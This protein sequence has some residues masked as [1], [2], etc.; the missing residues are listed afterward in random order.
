MKNILIS[1][2]VLFAAC[3]PINNNKAKQLN[4][5]SLR[6]DSIEKFKVVIPPIKPYY[7]A[8][9]FSLPSGKIVRYAPDDDQVLEIWKTGTPFPTVF[10]HIQNDTGLIQVRK[11]TYFAWKNLY[12]GDNLK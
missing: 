12:V 5:D 9:E 11:V 1:A 7:S 3:T 6:K 8:A 10:I 2:V 4:L